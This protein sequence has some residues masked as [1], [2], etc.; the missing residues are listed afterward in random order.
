MPS[1]RV[2]YSRAGIQR[3]YP[4]NDRSF[5]SVDAMAKHVHA[6]HL[7]ERVQKTEVG[8]RGGRCYFFGKQKAGDLQAVLWTKCRI[9]KSHLTSL[10]GGSI[11]ARI[12]SKV[13]QVYHKVH[14]YEIGSFTLY[15]MLC[16]W[17]NDEKV[18]LTRHSWVKL[19]PLL[20]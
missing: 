6:M 8:D 5:F 18:K 11:T 7:V 19:I 13:D 12:A 10:P 16:G 9:H 1:S 2:K 15:L 4:D 20:S 14:R 3:L 17:L